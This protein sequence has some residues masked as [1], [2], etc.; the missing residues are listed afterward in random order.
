M[1]DHICVLQ[2]KVIADRHDWVC[3]D[4]CGK[5]YVQVTSGTW[6]LAEHVE[7]FTDENAEE[8]HHDG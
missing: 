8:E 1:S 4:E 7:G 3:K 5:H 2:R 6:Q